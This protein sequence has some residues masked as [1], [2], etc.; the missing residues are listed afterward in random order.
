MRQK[1]NRG[2]RSVF[3][4]RS[5]APRIIGGV[6]A[7]V[8][9]VAVGFFGARWIHE[10][11]TT[12]PADTATTAPS[13]SNP[14]AP[15]P[16]SKPTAPVTPTVPA[17]ADTV[18]GFY[19]PFSALTGD[20]LATT[21]TAAKQAGFNAVLLDLKDADGH[22]YYRFTSASAVK[23]NSFT[24]EAL[25]PEALKS[26]FSTIRGAGLLPIPRLYA[27]QDNAA[28]KVL[29]D[30]R[31]SHKDNAG[32]VWYDGKK[33]NGAKAWLNPYADAA[34]TYIIELATELKN[35]GAG[36]V[37]LD[38]V[39]FPRQQSS[40]NFGNGPH[41]GLKQDEVLALFVEKARTALGNCP[42]MLACSAESALGTATQVYGG[43]PLTFGSSMASPAI[44]PGSLPAK[45]K[46]GDTVVQNTPDSL[47]QTVQALVNQMILRTKV[48]AENKQPTIAPFL[49]VAG[50][51]AAQVKQE[52]AG[53][54][55]G[56]AEN[57][58]L[59]SP[60][61]RYDFGAY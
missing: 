37:M 3:R 13:T 17:T 58:I 15:A 57:Y 34:H 7:A 42:V 12:V 48:L 10:H 6:L 40:A 53:C 19:L 51:T 38:G 45:I 9:I 14:T 54:I 24:S 25:T 35:A 56:G 22:M 21:L 8:A 30:A 60:D 16:T 55:A 4:K 1:L 28:A 49:Q 27:F 2:R 43:N 33:Q 23:V 29:S 47:Q 20:G 31:I 36:A 32:W 59:Y 26:L 46:V 39:Q 41:R 44:L 50:Y 18:R 5:K 52:I 61:G 11:P